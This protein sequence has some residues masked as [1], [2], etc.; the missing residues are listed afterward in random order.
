MPVLHDHLP[1]GRIGMHL[2]DHAR[3]YIE[4]TYRRPLPDR[5]LRAVLRFVLPHRERFRVALAGALLA[6]PLRPLVA[7]LPYVGRLPR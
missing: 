7:R 2:V 4:Q 5:M 3:A 1:V 6:K